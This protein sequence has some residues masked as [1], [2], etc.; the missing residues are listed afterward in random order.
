MRSLYWP[1]LHTGVRPLGVYTFVKDLGR[2][3]CAC[4]LPAV[5]T[6]LSY[7]PQTQTRSECRY[8]LVSGQL[9]QLLGGLRDLEEVYLLGFPG[10]QFE[11][12]QPHASVQQTFEKLRIAVVDFLDAPVR[13]FC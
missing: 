11:V 3:V 4:V 7:L 1:Q 8:N 2:V 9:H 5:F 13:S 6:P 12:E 10:C